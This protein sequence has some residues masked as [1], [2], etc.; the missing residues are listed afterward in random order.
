MFRCALDRPVDISFFGKY[1]P[2]WG[3]PLSL[4]SLVTIMYYSLHPRFLSIR[5][6]V[7]SLK[8]TKVKKALIVDF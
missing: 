6:S 4:A 3:F 5:V 1:V 8:K 7:I 2:D